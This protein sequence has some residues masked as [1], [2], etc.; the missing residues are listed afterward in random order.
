MNK[1]QLLISM[2][3]LKNYLL[4]L[5]MNLTQGFPA[6]ERNS[7]SDRI[8]CFTYKKARRMERVTQITSG[9]PQLVKTLKKES[10]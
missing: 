3:Y 2:Q 1:S 4:S 10:V 7:N 9:L 6:V 5:L 8:V